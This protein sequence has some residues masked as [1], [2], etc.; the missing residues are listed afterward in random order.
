MELKDKLQK[1]F[2]DD[3]P[4]S[5]IFLKEVIQPVIT[6]EID[7][8]NAEILDDDPT[9]RERAKHANIKSIR[10]VADVI[11]IESD[12]ISYFDVTVSDDSSITR[13]RVAI[14]H[15]LRSIVETHSHLLITF[16]YEDTENRAWRFSYAYKENTIGNMATAKRF[17]YIFGKE[18]KSRT[19]VERFV[20]LSDSRKSDDDFAK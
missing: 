3:Y 15:L 7:I 6:D 17:T 5:K 14:Q 8:I 16:H 4:G 12:K 19:A 1:I 18:Y 9:Y 20:V 2:E 11:D 10:Y 13:S